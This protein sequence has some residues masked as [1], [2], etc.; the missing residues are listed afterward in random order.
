MKQI[1]L[2]LLFLFLFSPLLV[3][4]KD[5]HLNIHPRSPATISSADERHYNRAEAIALMERSRETLPP[6]SSEKHGVLS[7]SLQDKLKRTFSDWRRQIRQCPVTQMTH[8][9]PSFLKI[10]KHLQIMPAFF[11]VCQQILV[12]CIWNKGGDSTPGT[13]PIR[14][15]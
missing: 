8:L 6:I 15:L 1:I 9:L 12:G 3:L 5:N 7:G 10:M 14:T 4:P 2:L 11:M 13:G